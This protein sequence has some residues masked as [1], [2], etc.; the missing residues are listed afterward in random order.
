MPPISPPAPLGAA[1]TYGPIRIV[2]GQ[3][4]D[5][6]DIIH[7]PLAD[8]TNPTGPYTVDEVGIVVAGHT[9][10]LPFD[11]SGLALLAAKT[12]DRRPLLTQVGYQCPG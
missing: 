10:Y 4:I 1:P 11:V 7:I 5:A 12:I 2:G 3:L 6:P 9:W 8:L